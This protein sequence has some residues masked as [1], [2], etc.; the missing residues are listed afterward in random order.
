MKTGIYKFFIDILGL[1]DKNLLNEA[2]KV[3]VVKHIKKG[4]YLTKIGD[5]LDYMSFLFS[6]G[7][8]RYFVTSSDGREITDCFATKKGQ[9]LLASGNLTDSFATFNIQAL[10]STDIL[11][12]P[13]VEILR[14]QKQYPEVLALEVRLA[15]E[16]ANIHWNLK[17]VHYRYSALERYC[18][19]L[20]NYPGL[21]DEI[22]NKYIASFLNMTPV[23]LSR[24][25]R[26]IREGK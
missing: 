11:L 20:E 8:L 12:I 15:F 26:K 2:V 24:L 19:F 18:W 1:E 25:R 23:T 4:E 6:D 3:S 13:I 17:M 21:I 9:S 16:S 14:L 22:N 5:S 7:I 10:T